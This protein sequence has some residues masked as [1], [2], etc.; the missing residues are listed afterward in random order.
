MIQRKLA[1]IIWGGNGGKPGE[2]DQFWPL[3]V[4]DEPDKK[5][6]GTEQEAAELRVKIEKAHRIKLG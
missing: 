2:F 1:Q 6:W 5:V 3:V 4:Q